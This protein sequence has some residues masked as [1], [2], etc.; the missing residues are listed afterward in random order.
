MAQR[1][2][3]TDRPSHVCTY[4]EVTRITY[5]VIVGTSLGLHCVSYITSSWREQCEHA[6]Q[7]AAQF[8]HSVHVTCYSHVGDCITAC[9]PA[10]LETVELYFF[11]H[12]H[13]AA[14]HNTMGHLPKLCANGA[15][16]TSF[17][18]TVGSHLR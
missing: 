12:A 18:F 10:L 2:V 14:C 9:L 3:F 7:S 11:T 1:R 4:F 5:E 15:G 17:L 8:C 16:R 6:P 13:G